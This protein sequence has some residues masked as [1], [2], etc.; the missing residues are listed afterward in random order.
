MN[1][2]LG[3]IFRFILE[4]NAPS[5]C[6][7]ADQLRAQEALISEHGNGIPEVH[8]TRGRVAHS[9]IVSKSLDEWVDHQPLG[10]R[11]LDPNPEIGNHE[12]SH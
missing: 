2:R 10:I 9:G 7:E 11:D 1:Q 5:H 6:I 12:D 3:H 4:C 8:A